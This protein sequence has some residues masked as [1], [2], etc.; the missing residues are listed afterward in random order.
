MTTLDE[1]RTTG[2]RRTTGAAQVL[3]RALRPPRRR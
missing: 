3:E 2:T 1:P